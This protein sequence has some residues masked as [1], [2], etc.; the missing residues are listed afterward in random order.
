MV[1]LVAAGVVA[2]AIATVLLWFAFQGTASDT[3]ASPSPSVTS[4]S[5]EPAPQQTEYPANDREYDL[6][7]LPAADVFG[8]HPELPV[9]DHPFG[10]STGLVAQPAG[11]AAPVFADPREDPVAMLPQ[12]QEFDGTIVPV[13]ERQQHW[14]RVLLTGRQSVPPEGDAA[15]LSGWLRV[16]DVTLTENPHRVEVSLS[17]RTVDVVSPDGSERIADDFAWG[18]EQTPTPLGR[19]FVM[20]TRVTSFDYARGH[21]IVYLSVQSPTLASFGGADAAVTAFHYHDVRTGA[22]SNGCIRL[23]GQ[24][25]TRLAELPEGT[26]VT[27]R[28]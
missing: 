5:R 9:D 26:M 12:T 10:E 15:Q 14:L 19:S 21:P 8:V 13:V 23:G 18:T 17:Q 28:E 11:E 25:I 1:I 4:E 27:I 7:A 3:T 20:M 22:I 16:A 2:C 24:A 6:S